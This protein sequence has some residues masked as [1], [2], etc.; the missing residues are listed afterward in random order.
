MGT[1]QVKHNHIF[2]WVTEDNYV[3]HSVITTN[4]DSRVDAEELLCKEWVENYGNFPTPNWE[5]VHSYAI[6]SPKE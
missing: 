4:D 2:V 1:Q 6:T 3:G 5:C